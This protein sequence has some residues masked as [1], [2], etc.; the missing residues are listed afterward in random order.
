[1]AGFLLRTARPIDAATHADKTA[2]M[3]EQQPKTIRFDDIAF[4]PRFAYGEMCTIGET[5]GKECGG[6]IGAGFARMT[7]AHI[8]WTVTYDEVLTVLEGRLRVHAGGAVHDLGPRD[9]LWIPSG[10]E[11]VYEAEDA[12]VHYAIHP[13]TL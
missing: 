7:G 6:R 11:L 10:T 9:T 4:R 13:V 8:P 12:L 5:V 1:M 2:G 3:S